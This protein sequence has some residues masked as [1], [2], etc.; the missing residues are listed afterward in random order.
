MVKVYFNLVKN[1]LR[2]LDEIRDNPKTAKYYEGVK[3]LLIEA[4]LYEEPV[5]EE[6]PETPAEEPETPVE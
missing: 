4:G 3:A 6:D 5:V 2:T 1:N